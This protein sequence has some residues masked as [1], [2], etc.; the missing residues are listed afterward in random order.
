MDESVGKQ[1]EAR[2][3]G[4]I[5]QGQGA[6]HGFKKMPI[7]LSKSDLA[8]I[9]DCWKPGRDQPNYSKLKKK[10]FTPEVLARIDITSDEYNQIKEFDR[11]TTIKIIEV[12]EI[13]NEAHEYAKDRL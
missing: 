8:Q 4:Q 12:L 5:K 9:L 7:T 3:L 1:Q 6:D 13:E 10:F 2:S 11:L